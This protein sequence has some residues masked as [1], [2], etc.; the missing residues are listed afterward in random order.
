MSA[1]LFNP[2]LEQGATFQFGVLIS[3]SSGEP[4]DL[5]GCSF[6]G[7]VRRFTSDAFKVIDLTCAVYGD[8]EDGTILVSLTPEQTTDLELDYSTQAERKI[9]PLSYDVKMVMQDS[10]VVRLVEG[11]ILA[12]PQDTHEDPEEEI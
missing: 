12:S 10:T 1:Y 3:D 5:T 4:V 7:Q 11:V 8:P 6:A 2:T 9:T